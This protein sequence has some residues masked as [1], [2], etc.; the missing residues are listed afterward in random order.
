VTDSASS[1]DVLARLASLL[2]ELA[3]EGKLGTARRLFADELCRERSRTGGVA[4]DADSIPGRFGMVGASPAMQSVY[5]LLER[6][7]PTDVPVLI[8]GETGTGKELV[9]RALH[10]HGMRCDHPFL[11]ENCAAI[12]GPLLES[13]L[14]GHVKGSF[15]GAIANREGYFC[16]ADGGTVFLD[17]IGDMPMEM[18]V[19]LLRVLEEGEVRPVGSSEVRK[20]DVRIVAATNKDL[21][22]EREQGRFRDDLFYR[23]Q[24]ISINLPPLRDRSGDVDHLVRFFLAQFPSPSAR[25]DGRDPVP[26]MDEKAM[27]A[28]RSYSWPGNVRELENEVQR[29]LALTSGKITLSELS[30]GVAGHSPS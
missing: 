17:E 10:D 15:T 5:E 21:Q 14:F 4:V 27:A 2:E 11:A 1:G 22:V 7:A 30:P 19:K 25:T 16:T 26:T 18:Q 6:V 9:A 20:V 12:P 13:E 3:E 23:L 29:A 8:T 28:L 24:V